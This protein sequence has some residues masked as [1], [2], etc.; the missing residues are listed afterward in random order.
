MAGLLYATTHDHFIPFVNPLRQ[1]WHHIHIAKR[2][3]LQAFAV[4]EE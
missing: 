3:H 4:L 1:V 2:V